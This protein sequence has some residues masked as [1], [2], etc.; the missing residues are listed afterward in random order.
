MLLSAW[1]GCQLLR[2]AA[3]HAEELNEKHNLVFSAERLFGLYLDDQ[4]VDTGPSERHRDHTV[5]AIGWQGSPPSAL[6]TPR[7]GIDVFITPE[8]TL[9]GNIGFFSHT[10]DVGDGSVTST[11]V[12]FGA[13]VGYA[14]RFTH[15]IS[16][17]PRAGLT[18]STVSTEGVDGDDHVL[19]LSIDAPFTFMPAENFAIL[20]GPCID[21]GFLGKENGSDY[22]EIMFGL[23]VGL[24]GWVGL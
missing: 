10:Q 11:G 6:T 4:S 22:S 15:A 21:L 5:F 9:G 7:L 19:A 20:V 18:Y 1:L 13:R 2:A 12:L 17:W 14:F 23:M 24:S 16:F 3:A 8:L